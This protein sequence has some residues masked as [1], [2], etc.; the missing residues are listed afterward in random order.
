[1]NEET[2]V[3]YNVAP[4]GSLQM[5]SILNEAA[6]RHFV[7]RPETGVE[8][9]IK[10]RE[11][12]LTSNVKAEGTG[13]DPLAVTIAEDLNIKGDITLTITS[14]NGREE[15]PEEN[16]DKFTQQ[17]LFGADV[18]HSQSTAQED[19]APQN[20]KQTKTTVNGKEKT[21]IEYEV[22]TQT[23]KLEIE[24]LTWKLLSTKIMSD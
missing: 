21:V 14:T 22:S 9:E 19:G 23:T 20:Y 10:G 8:K 15:T 1:L 16:L 6:F 11:L 4:V 18:K 7:G 24:S 2:I 3:L 12:Q 13:L 17:L 5:D